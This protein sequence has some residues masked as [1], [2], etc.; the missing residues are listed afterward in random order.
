MHWA[1]DEGVKGTAPLAEREG[2][3]EAFALLRA[4]RADGIVVASLD[5]LARDVVL[6]EQLHAELGTMG[7]ALRS[8]L[9]GED[10]ALAHDDADPSR[11]LVRRILAA[12]AAY[13]RDMIKLRLE[14]GRSRK[15]A[16]GGYTAGRPPYGWIASGKELVPVEA[17]QRVRQRI[18]I[19]SGQG[20]SLRAIAELLNSEGVLSKTGR[21]W[22]SVAVN[23]VLT[24]TRRPIKP[25]PRAP[26]A[27][28]SAASERKAV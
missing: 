5:R 24:N 11:A 8:A 10:H 1:R 23:S 19:W 6:Q 7:A 4:D 26:R 28:R 25:R 12:I 27:I 13:E 22:S 14:G 21:Q 3:V 16:A 17:E 20:L 18:K 15:A 2:L 9:P